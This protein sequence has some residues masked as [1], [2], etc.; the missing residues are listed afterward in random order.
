[1]FSRRDGF[2]VQSSTTQSIIFVAAHAA[3][4]PDVQCLARSPRAHAGTMC[5]CADEPFSLPLSVL[6]RCVEAF[7]SKYC[8]LTAELHGAAF[9]L[10]CNEC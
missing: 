4:Q 2:W 10:H 3:W 9:C 8:G 5:M 1:M 6:Y 7:P